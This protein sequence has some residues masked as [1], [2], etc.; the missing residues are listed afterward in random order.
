M[1]PRSLAVTCVLAFGCA[2][3]ASAPPAPLPAVSLSDEF[4]VGR[5]AAVVNGKPISE[6]EL[7]VRLR[8]R[9]GFANRDEALDALIVLE[10]QAQ[11]A[12]AAGLHKSPD[13]QA[14]MALA[15]ARFRDARRVTLSKTWRLKTLS[16]LAPAPE[17]ELKTWF[18]SNAEFIQTEWRLKRLTTRAPADADR[19]L[20][21]LRAGKPF[22]EVVASFPG[23][24][25][26]LGPLQFDAVPETWWQALK[27]LQPGQ[28]TGVI[29]QGERF[30]ILQVVER[31]MLPAADFSS[32]RPRIAA[33]LHAQ[34][35]EQRMKGL[36]DELKQ[37]AVIEKKPFA[38]PST[39]GSAPLEE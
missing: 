34:N 19:A 13:F 23:E 6:A 21:A 16:A 33:I 36:G 10:L 22:D 7:S 31:K 17:D 35:Y 15:A 38:P 4:P 32:V 1:N 14:E 27:P 37:G 2:K 28:H 12:E 9:G 11:Q 25:V 39:P 8:D 3:E 24:Q 29:P 26:D 18:S 30:V 20:A 5:V